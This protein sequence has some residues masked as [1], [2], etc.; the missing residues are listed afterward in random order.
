MT[1]PQIIML[2]HAAWI[3]GK[4]SDSRTKTEE[5]EDKDDPVV[6]KGKR[7][8]QLTSAEQAQYYAM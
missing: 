8:S 3:N 1:M 4:R 7:L 5:V 6:F 2:N